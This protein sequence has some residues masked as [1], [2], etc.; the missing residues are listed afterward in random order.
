MDS[1]IV[2]NGSNTSSLADNTGDSNSFTK[3]FSD[4]MAELKGGN[5]NSSRLSGSSSLI[6]GDEEVMDKIFEDSEDSI[7][8]EPTEDV[9]S[10]ASSH[11]NDFVDNLDEETNQM[12]EIDNVNKNS[13]DES[14]DV[15]MES[16]PETENT[17]TTVENLDPTSTKEKR[18][19]VPVDIVW[20]QGGDKVY[21]TGS[22]TGW[23]KMIGLLP[24]PNKLGILHVR[25]RLP[26]GVHRFRFVVDNELRYSD[27]LPTATDQMG[28]FVNYLEVRSTDSTEFTSHLDDDTDDNKEQNRISAF[29]L[30]KMSQQSRIALKIKNEPDNV[31]DGFMRFYDEELKEPEPEYTN[32][33]PS[34]FT[35][36]RIMEK[37]YTKLDY[38]RTKNRSGGMLPAQLPPHLEYAILNDFPN[39]ASTTNEI[40][41]GGS[42][43]TPNHV[44]L[45]HLLTSSIKHGTL[46][47]ATA[48]RYKD[49][50]I[51]QV[52]YS[53]I[54]K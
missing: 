42:L 16:E 27:F 2:K 12:V 4:L 50:Y 15:V 53:P 29:K 9:R 13:I 22:F 6:L 5:R 26:P 32:K 52:Y 1:N 49:K 44:V 18:K 33:L 48:V 11:S 3:D 47:L 19:M 25:L 38:E 10:V 7:S 45:N 21:V 41:H 46:G 39:I 17:N 43:H 28:N 14:E 54:K 37:Y 24:I 23:T 35:D 51:T 30:K 40:A 8:N 20:E 31:G 36:P 34:I